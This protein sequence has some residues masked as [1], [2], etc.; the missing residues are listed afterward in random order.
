MADVTL[1]FQFPNYG[2]AADFLAKL[3]GENWPTPTATANAKPATDEV[4]WRE[5]DEPAQ[6][7]PKASADPWAEDAKPATRPA[8]KANA[9]HAAAGTLFPASGVY[10]KE[11]PNGDRTW[12]FGVDG[13][14][15]CDCGYPAAQVSGKKG[16]KT[17]TAYWCPIGFTKN[18]RDKCK[19]SEF[20]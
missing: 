6:T 1:S 8:A 4:P 19:F 9:Q 13:A 16:T 17:W 10:V 7:K 11:T 3:T 20:A 2:E 12:T 15:D 18:Y 14:P 5:D